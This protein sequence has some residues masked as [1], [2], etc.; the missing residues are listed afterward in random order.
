M[1]VLASLGR[2]KTVTEASSPGLSVD[3]VADLKSRSQAE[4]LEEMVQ[5]LAKS[6]HIKD[7]EAF[8]E[9]ILER[10][11]IMSTGIGF[12]LA[13]P[14]AKTKGVTG[15]VLALGRSREGVDYDS[16]DGEPVHIVVMIAGPEGQQERY[17]RLLAHIMVVLKKEEN[18]RRILA[19]DDPEEIVDIFDEAF[20]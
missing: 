10:E 13:I 1:A 17:L 2:R 5:L 4:C 6:P 7:I 18:R 19:A 20:S 14:H 8:R 3:L 11:K 9:A 15:F 16:L 12:G